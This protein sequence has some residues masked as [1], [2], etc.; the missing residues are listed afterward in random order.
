MNTIANNIENT[1]KALLEV[2]LSIPK[3]KFDTIPFEGSWTAGQVTEHVLKS[4]AGFV[5]VLEG[6]VKPAD[7]NAEEHVQMLRDIFLDFDHKMK[8]LEFILPTHNTH[9]RQ[10]IAADLANTL[11]GIAA[12]A[13]VEDLNLLCTDFEMPNLGH[14]TRIELINFVDVHTQRHIHQLKNIRTYLVN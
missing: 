10:V 11:A 9:D 12:V 3:E 2:I 8:S 7:R 1:S 13:K 4:C 6:N 5:D 14:L